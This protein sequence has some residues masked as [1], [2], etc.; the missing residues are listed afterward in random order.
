[1]LSRKMMS[2]IVAIAIVMTVVAGCKGKVDQIKSSVWS[3]DKGTTLGKAL[4]KYKGFGKTTWQLIKTDNGKE[5]VEFAGD[6]IPPEAKIK[7]AEDMIST[8]PKIREQ[9]KGNDRAM[10]Y[11]SQGNIHNYKEVLSDDIPVLKG[12]RVDKNNIELLTA[13]RPKVERQLND[14][15]SNAEKLKAFYA[16]GNKLQVVYEFVIN[17]DKSFDIAA[18]GCRTSQDKQISSLQNSLD[19][20]KKIYDSEPIDGVCFEPI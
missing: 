19:V 2:E 11:Y 15:L 9:I 16:S 14:A 20:L 13:F 12:F 1:M 18:A 6:L 17:E 4:D 8:A 10:Y 7:S 5:I 3:G